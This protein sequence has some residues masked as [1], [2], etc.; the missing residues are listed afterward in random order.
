MRIPN[1]KRQVL[2]HGTLAKRSTSTQVAEMTKRQE[3]MVKGNIPGE[4]AMGGGFDDMFKGERD[5][6]M[7]T[8]IEDGM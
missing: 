7:D 1:H 4:K 5:E 2:N 3:M 8:G 6:K